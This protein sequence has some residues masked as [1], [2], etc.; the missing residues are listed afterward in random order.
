MLEKPKHLASEYGAQFKDRS[1]VEAYQYRP[2][3]PAEVFDVLAGLIS[4]EPRRVLDV[5]CGTGY[6]ARHFVE[7]VE[8]LDAVDFSQHMIETGKRL[9]N[10]DHL[11]LRWLYGAVEDVALDPP[12]ALVTAGESLHWM[13]WHVVLPR[14]K[15]SLVPGGYLAI[16]SHDNTLPE[17]WYDV[18]RDIIPQ[19]STNKDFEPYDLI[20]ELERRGLFQK[21]GVKMT[22][23]VPFV[24]S[25]DDYIESFHSRNGF[26]RDRM[27]PDQA[28][29]FD[30]ETRKILL[31]SHQNGVMRLQVI[32][33]VIWGLPMG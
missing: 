5:G 28:A 29:A 4:A 25:I 13:D 22:A 31:K 12:Y 33:T 10:G 11:H 18:L 27:I 14:F 20:E 23:P 16:V 6:L 15:E 17:P 21:V 32:G 26:S 2:P 19:Y 30:Q 24:Q 1:I 9:P 7:Y 3:Y 8:Q